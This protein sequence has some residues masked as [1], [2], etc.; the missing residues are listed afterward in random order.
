MPAS[1]RTPDPESG[2]LRVSIL[3]LANNA[4]EKALPA[5][6]EEL[7]QTRTVYPGTNLRLVYDID[8]T[9]PQ[10]RLT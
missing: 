6:I 9:T 4:T 10:N 2:I 1:S 3:G 5:L 7:N 8:G